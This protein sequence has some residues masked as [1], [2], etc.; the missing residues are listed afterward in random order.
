MSSPDPVEDAAEHLYGVAFADF[1]KERDARA[2]ELRKAGEKEA[3]AEVGKLPKPSQVAY[4]ANQLARSG[5]AD[6]LLEAGSGTTG[7]DPLFDRFNAAA[8]FC[9]AEGS[10]IDVLDLSGLRP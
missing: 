7:D 2:K 5:D 6:E 8:Q 4:A 10:R 1:I 9:T 3:A